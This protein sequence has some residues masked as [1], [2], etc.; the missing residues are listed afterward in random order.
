MDIVPLFGLSSIKFGA[1]KA[2]AIEVFGNPD[3]VENESGRNGVSSEIWEYQSHGIRLYFDPDL[4]FILWDISITS[5]NVQL[6]SINPIGIKESEL[7]AYFPSLVLEVNDGIFKEYVDT[8]NELLFFLRDNIVKR[9]DVSPN[10]DDY[11][12]RFG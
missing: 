11:L 7:L 3:A 6:N 5:D 10:L 12:K 2:H 4:N 1:S 9:I 8:K